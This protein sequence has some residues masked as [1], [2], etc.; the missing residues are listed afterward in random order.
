[1]SDTN[2]LFDLMFPN[3]GGAL[4]EDEVE[5]FP[6]VI[7]YNQDQQYFWTEIVPQILVRRGIICLALAVPTFFLSFWLAYSVTRYLINM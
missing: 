7:D 4:E 6:L 1:M 3:S 2:E 5:E